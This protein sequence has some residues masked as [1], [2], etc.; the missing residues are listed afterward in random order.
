MMILHEVGVRVNVRGKITK[1][2]TQRNGI[3][4]SL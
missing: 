2:S 4:G 3:R 1:T